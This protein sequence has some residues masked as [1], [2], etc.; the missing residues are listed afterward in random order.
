[1]ITSINEVKDKN[2]TVIGFGVSHRPLV[3]LLLEK[4]ANVTVRDKKSVEELGEE[5]LA[6]SGK[7]EF[8]TGEKYLENIGGE[9]VF[10]TPGMRNDKPEFIEAVK[11]GSELISEMELFFR[12]CPCKIFA[13]TGSEGKT[14]STTLIYNFLKAQGYT[15]HLGGNIGKPLLP[16]IE[17]IKPEDFAVV[18]LSSFQLNDMTQSGNISVV[19]NITPNHLDWHTSMDEYIEAKK[20]IFKYQNEKGVLIVNKDDEL[21]LSCA[22]EA[23][24]EVRYFSFKGETENGVYLAE[25]GE[26]ISTV[27]GKRSVIMHRDDIKLPGDHNVQNYM[28]AAAAV[29][30]YVEN[31]T[32]KKIAR[33]FG[34]VEHRM[35]FVREFE[36]VR[37]YNDS[38]A[39]TPTRTIAGLKAQTQKIIIIAGGYDK[40]L[41]YSPLAPYLVKH[42]KHMVL[43]GATKEKIKNALLN[44]KDYDP[45]ELTVEETEDFRSAIYAA[46]KAAKAGDIV[47]FSPASASFDMFPNFEVKGRFY[48]DTVNNFKENE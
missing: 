29:S 31:E 14:T 16:D 37:Y 1:M 24:G 44:C 38:I 17:S 3:K 32:I 34:G 19:T 23:K 30:G 42:V 9:I 27:G 21:A 13:V 39:T 28:T 43:C 45:K 12:L 26:I 41:D 2:I 40:N 47:Y 46:R 22:K 5:A 36:G 35:E 11:N 4:G 33:E 8:I 18:E 6:L 10:K 15:C 20:N 25:N 7:V 48:K